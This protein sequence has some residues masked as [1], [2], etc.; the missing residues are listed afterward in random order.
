M[1]G[2]PP[3]AS[4]STIRLPAVQGEHDLSADTGEARGL[5]LAFAPAAKPEGLLRAGH[6]IPYR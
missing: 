3:P 2:E 4:R 1:V 6:H 5:A